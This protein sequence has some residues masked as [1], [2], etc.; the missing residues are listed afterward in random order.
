MEARAAR[1]AAR[2]SASAARPAAPRGSDLSL[3]ELT[4]M[5][6]RA[7]EEERR[8][9][10]ERVSTMSREGHIDPDLAAYL[11]I[12]RLRSKKAEPKKEAP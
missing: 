3:D 9:L 10:R 11:Y 6:S 7:R 5:V 8:R 2:A 12:A 1:A 4:G